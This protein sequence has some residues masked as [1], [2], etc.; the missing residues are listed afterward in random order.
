MAHSFSLAHLTT[1]AW[2]PPE[3]IYNASILGYDHASIRIISMGVSRE[4]NFDLARDAELFARTK[5]AL[6][7]TGLSLHDIELAKI[8]G[9]TDV[10]TYAGAF[11]A[12]EKLGAK[13]VISSIWTDETPRYLADFA[14]VC[15]LAADHGLSVHLEFPSWAA[16]WNLTRARQVLEHVNRPNAG[17]LLDSLHVHRSGVTL[18]EMRACPKEWLTFAHICDGPL[19]AP[20]RSDTT[21]LIHTGRDARLYVGEGGIDIAAMVG[22][23]HEDAVLSIELPHVERT[24]CYGATEHARRCLVTA[25]AYCGQ[26]GIAISR[27]EAPCACVR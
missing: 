18:D 27:E 4:S 14:A 20:Q 24:A 5:N 9:T 21:A 12:A 16:I 11:A 2:T 6:D 8:D 3:L 25:R 19:P 1:L 10:R 23:L 26:H 17:L 15:D 22:C 13:A 7:E